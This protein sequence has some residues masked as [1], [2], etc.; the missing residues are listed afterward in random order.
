MW[1]NSCVGIAMADTTELGD[2]LPGFVLWPGIEGERGNRLCVLISDVHCTDCTVGNQTASENDWRQFFEQ[3]EFAAGN[4]GEEKHPARGGRARQVDELILVLN[5]DVI[6]LIRSSRWAEAGV[7][8]WHRDHPRFST[9]VLDIMREIVRIHADQRSQE[10]TRPYTGFFYWMQQSLARLRDRGIVVT[11]VPVMGNHDKELQVVAEARRMFY[12][13]CLGI[14]AQ[15]ITQDYRRWVAAQLGT[16]PDDPYPRLPFYFADAGLRLLATHG[17]WR[18]QDNAR[19]TRL[20]NPLQGWAPQRWREEQ[21]RAF[22]EPCFGD[23][24]AAGMLS[25]FIWSVAAFVDHSTASGSRLCNLLNEMDLYRPSVRAVVRLLQESRGMARQSREARGLHKRLVDC[26]RDCL[27]AWLAHAATHDSAWGSTRLGLF[28]L[29]CFSRLRIYRI[30]IWLMQ[31]MAK[32]QE[33]E[34]S[35]ALHRLL[36]L[37]AFRPE[38]RAL[39]LRLHVEGHTHVALE[40]DVQ[41]GRRRR[42]ARKHGKAGGER[43]NFTYINLGAWRDR[44]VPKRNRGFRRRGMGRALFVFDLARDAREYRQCPDSRPPD[45]Y[46]FYVRDTT[47]WSDGKDSL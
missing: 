18:D 35:I 31:L 12:E 22:T 25:R 42:S 37:P 46:R 36:A 16:P 3:L 6:D 19:A 33:P 47:S 30:E 32:A 45:R 34:S 7:Y 27:R 10:G 5:G 26:F 4:P 28:V 24:V 11:I 44:I 13:R 17:Q 41:F 40:E 38:Y 43:N 8:P 21:Y 29:S 14:T 1:L 20:W 2:A 23:T 9:I 39:G 15:E